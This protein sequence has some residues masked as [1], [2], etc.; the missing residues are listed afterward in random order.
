[1]MRLVHNETGNQ[2]I[3]SHHEDIWEKQLQTNTP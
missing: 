2:Y 3:N 1:M